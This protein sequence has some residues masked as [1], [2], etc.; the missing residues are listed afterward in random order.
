VYGYKDGFLEIGEYL[1]EDDEFMQTGQQ[2]ARPLLRFTPYADLTD[3]HPLAKTVVRVFINTAFN[4]E[5]LTI[6]E[7]ELLERH[8]KVL[9]SVLD[10][11]FHPDKP[12]MTEMWEMN[13]KCE[14]WYIRDI[15]VA[16]LGRLLY[17]LNLCDSW[18]VMLWLW[19][20]SSCGKTTLI[21]LVMKSLFPKDTCG[22]IMDNFESVFGLGNLFHLQAVSFPDIKPG[23][24]LKEATFQVMVEGGQTSIAIKNG[25]AKMPLWDKPM[26]AGSQHPPTP[27]IWPDPKQAVTKRVFCAHFDTIPDT[28]NDRLQAE[29]CAAAHL[30]PT[31]VLLTRQYCR[32]KQFVGNRGFTE[33]AKTLHYVR[34]QHETQRLSNNHLLRFLVQTKGDNS[35]K[36]KIWWCEY[37]EG[38]QTTIARLKK[39]YGAWMDFSEAKKP[40]LQGPFTKQNLQGTL[41]AASEHLGGK[42]EYSVP[43]RPNVKQCFYCKREEPDKMTGTCCQQYRDEPQT[44][45][46]KKSAKGLT[47]Q[48]CI[49]NL[50]MREEDR[51]GIGG[52][53]ADQAGSMCPS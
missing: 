26:C 15:M 32:L 16:L 31:L 22:V 6:T 40:D 47:E 21:D 50:V 33:W 4:H 34:E 30:G 20:E 12:G 35:S 36:E 18:R 48:A 38:E 3:D 39:S 49:K 28:T 23:C 52:L 24:P 7:A 51:S 11:S 9:K 19:G 8:C 37:A 43:S 13:G 2:K 10:P 41:N 17:K 53:F 45:W 14:E 5:W 1:P 42:L 27:D 25:I 29:M 44:K 46:G